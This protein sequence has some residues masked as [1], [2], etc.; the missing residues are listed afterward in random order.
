MSNKARLA[1]REGT[2]ITPER[3]LLRIAGLRFLDK[4]II[5]TIF[6]KLKSS[7]IITLAG[8]VVSINSVFS[9]QFYIPRYV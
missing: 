5:H 2:E 8:V 1:R 9:G 4:L 7:R 6:L 3:M